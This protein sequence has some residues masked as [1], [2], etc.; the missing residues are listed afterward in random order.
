LLLDRQ[1]KLAE[2]YKAHPLEMGPINNLRLDKKDSGKE[3]P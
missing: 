3:G 2:A 1:Y